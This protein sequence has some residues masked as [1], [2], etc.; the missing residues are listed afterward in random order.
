LCDVALLVEMRPADFDWDLVLADDRRRR[1]AVSAALGLAGALLDADL[2]G[3][4]AAYAVGALPPWVVRTTYRQWGE[5]LGHREPLATYRARPAIFFAELRRHWPNAIEAS[6]AL[7]ATFGRGPRF[8]FQLA[9]VALR[10]ARF[11][12]SLMR[13]RPG[14]RPVALKTRPA[15]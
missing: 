1:S 5:G 7:G 8:A 15:A 10:A 13:R 2:S 3:S 11:G 12:V 6:A 4:P 14:A 9:H